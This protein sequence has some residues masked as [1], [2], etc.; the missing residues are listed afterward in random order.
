M[1]ISKR[2]VTQTRLQAPSGNDIP[3]SRLLAEQGQPLPASVRPGGIFDLVSRNDDEAEQLRARSPT[4][5]QRLAKEVAAAGAGPSPFSQEAW[6]WGL[7]KASALGEPSSSA[8]PSSSSAIPPPM[9]S[10]PAPAAVAA[11]EGV[12]A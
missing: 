2:C 6:K 7:T 8:S 12:A 3:P 9:S 1:S 11:K 5:L 4:A 10:P